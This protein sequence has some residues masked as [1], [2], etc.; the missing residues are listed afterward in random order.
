MNNKLQ[1]YLAKA[2]EQTTRKEVTV[3]IDG[4]EWKVRQLNLTELRDCERMADKGDK[5]D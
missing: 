2:N 4:E 5:T 3:T 1:K